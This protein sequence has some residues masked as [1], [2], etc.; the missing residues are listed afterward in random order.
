[1]RTFRSIAFPLRLAWA[2]LSRRPARALLLALGVAAAAGALAVVLG[3]SL[4]AQDVSAG[5]ALAGVPVSKRSVAVTYADLGLPRNGVTRSQ[6]EPLVNQTLAGL[7]P[8]KPVRAVQ[9]KLLRVG[10]ALTN[11]AALDDLPKWVRLTSGRFPRECTPERCEVVQLGGSGEVKGAPGLRI[12]K[13]GEG[14]LT[15]P[16]PFGYLP[17]AHST[18]RLG[19]SF[20][21]AEPPFVVADGFDRL[22]TLPSLHAFYRTYSWVVPLEPASVHPWDIDAF[23]ARA[24]R[25]AST[26]RAKSLF[27]D[28]SA[29]T[30]ELAAARATGQVA[31]RRLLLVGGQVAALLLAFAVLAAVGMRRD[32]D[33]GRQRLTWFGGR[34]WQVFLVTAAETVAVALGGAVLGWAIGSG[35]TALLAD[36]AGSPPGAVLAHSALA[37]SGLAAAAGLALA[38]ALVLIVVLSV[39]PLSLG[40]L[41]FTPLDAAALGALLAIVLA[42]ARG[43]VDARSLG[44]GGTGTLLLLLPGLVTF[45]VAVAAARL[46]VPGL[47]LLER[48]ARGS[49]IHVRLAAL[50]LARSPGRAAVAV[51]FLVASL[52]LGLFAVVYRSTL[53]DGI[54]EQA[55]YAVPRDFTVREDLSPAGLVAPLEA[56]P[57][58]SYQALGAE[59]TPIIRRTASAG[60]VGQVTLLGVPADAIGSLD[61]WQDRFSPLSRDEIV[62]GIAPSSPPTLRGA[63]IPAGAQT[64]ELPY[65]LRGGAVALTAVVL[66][67]DGLFTRIGLGTATGRS[68]ALTGTVPESAHGGRVVALELSRALSVE[69]HGDFARLDGVLTLAPLRAGSTVLTDYAGWNGFDGVRASGATLRFLLTNEAATP[70]FQPP[71][72]TDSTPPPVVA[73]PRLAAAAGAG[74]ILP[75]RF[76]GGAVPVRVVGTIRRFPS[77]SGDF[78][79]GDERSLFVALNSSSPGTTTPNELWLAGPE[80]VGDELERPP[81]APT[82]VSSRAALEHR[83]RADPLARGSLAALTGAAVVA[84]LLALAGLGVLLLGDARDDR[85]ELFDLETQGAG[86]ATLRRHLRLRAALVAILGLLGGLAAAALLAV[87]AVDLVT[88]TAGAALPEPPL[89]LAVDWRFVGVCCTAYAVLTAAL[90]GLSTRRA[91]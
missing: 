66:G 30:A 61:G 84:F 16:V 7:A 38:A 19:E 75:L 2:R 4:V 83:L 52:G 88:L 20:G 29:P 42:F 59:V 79:L 56:A 21:L 57:I 12:V 89:A 78:V 25:A 72:A 44:Q 18:S 11:L 8:G 54:S 13:V 26:L 50:S 64:L 9:F 55:A 32:V 37:S 86:P 45:V 41:T 49:R 22:S 74:G 5:R 43:D 76:S 47:R 63:E 60:D 24:T 70:R 77:A 27:L 62:D 36:R 35:L 39:P 91:V 31:G 90:V 33:E 14:V 48:A 40:G 65:T 51:T 85:R 82:S 34:R 17:G 46:L 53:D 73:T 1:M 10:G 3:G 6:L 87:L 81:F 67:P 80:S 69:G 68:G 71:Q 15:S 28:L 23:E 58:S